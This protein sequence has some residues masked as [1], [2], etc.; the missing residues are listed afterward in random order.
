MHYEITILPI[1]FFV[2]RGILVKSDSEREVDY[3]EDGND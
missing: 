1:V 2:Q 3:A